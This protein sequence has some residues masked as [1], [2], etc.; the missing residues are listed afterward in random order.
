MVENL[1]P[2]LPLKDIVIM[3]RVE[4]LRCDIEE[5]ITQ[6]LLTHDAKVPHSDEGWKLLMDS[7]IEEIRKNPHKWPHFEITCDVAHDLTADE[8]AMRVT[9]TIHLRLVEGNE[10]GRDNADCAGKS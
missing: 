1:E 6:H 7:I 4:T 2:K 3:M 8:K 9:P 10:D 5:C